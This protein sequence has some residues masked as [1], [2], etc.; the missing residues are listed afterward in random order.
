MQS[1]QQIGN[2][3]G[4]SLKTTSASEDRGIDGGKKARGRKRRIFL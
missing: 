3:I 4:E 1:S 2:L